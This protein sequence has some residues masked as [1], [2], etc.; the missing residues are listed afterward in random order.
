M[1]SNKEINDKNLHFTSVYNTEE[2]LN[3]Y[4][5]AT[6]NVGILE[7]EKELLKRFA[8]KESKIADLG[9]GTGRFV[10]SAIQNGYKN[11]FGFDI[12]EKSILKAKAIQKSNTK[13]Q[14]AHFLEFDLS[15]D[16]YEKNNDF[17]FMIFTFNSLMC[18]PQRSHK[19]NSLKN[20]YKALNS[21]GYLVFSC[22]EPEGN[23]LRLEMIAKQRQELKVKNIK[24]WDEGDFVY[25]QGGGVGVL[26]YYT[27]QQVF[28]LLKEA[29]LPMP[30]LIS[31]RDEL[32]KES[33]KAQEFCDNTTYYVIQ[34]Q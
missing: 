5:K 1:K 2:S 19:I 17:D 31:K 21:K 7:S 4:T 32:A 8:N 3:H 20:A 22:A 27:R 23:D 15:I 30:K 28:E 24:D 25:Y 14:S 11:I 26:S 34:K 13:Y 6:F 9:C 33:Q 16:E 12:S 18:M 29:N 10:F